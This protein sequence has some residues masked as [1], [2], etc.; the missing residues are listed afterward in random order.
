M[1]E[2]LQSEWFDDDL[3]IFWSIICEDPC[4]WEAI[5]MQAGLWEPQQPPLLFPCYLAFTTMNFHSLYYLKFT[6]IETT[7]CIVITPP[8]AVSLRE[9]GSP[10]RGQSK[11]LISA[12]CDF[13]LMHTPCSNGEKMMDAYDGKEKS[14]AF[15][16]YRLYEFIGFLSWP[17]RGSTDLVWT[18]IWCCWKWSGQHLL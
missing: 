14:T 9:A 12:L 18:Q 6:G 13:W 5:M 16:M 15:L 17:N 10:L 2:L 4:N 1:F 7:F 8:L 11:C 3:I